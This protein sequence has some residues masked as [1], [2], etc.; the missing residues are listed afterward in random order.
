MCAN[1]SARARWGY[2]SISTRAT[3]AWVRAQP[4]SEERVPQVFISYSHKD[5]NKADQLV[6]RLHRQE[7]WR[8]QEITT[9][10]DD[11]QLQAG[12]FW[13][14]ELQKALDSSFA[15]VAICTRASMASSEVLFEIAYAIGRHIPVIPLIWDA[16]CNLQPFLEAY[17]RLD[18]SVSQD[19]AS[20]VLKLMKLSA[21]GSGAAKPCADSRVVSGDQ[22]ATELRQFAGEP[23][24][25]LDIFAYSGETFTA[26]LN[27]LFEAMMRADRPAQIFT[28]RVLL[29]DWESGSS[30]LPGCARTASVA[31]HNEKELYRNEIMRSQERIRDQLWKQ[32]DNWSRKLN[33][34]F[35]L[36]VYHIDPFHKG[37][38]INGRLGFWSLYPMERDISTK[39]PHILDYQGKYVSFAEFRSEGTPSEA[40]ALRS[41]CEWFNTVWESCC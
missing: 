30:F 17:Q 40:L 38:L 10:L 19:W 13:R 21:E 1:G 18:F 33:L 8:G 9:Y 4:E 11:Q 3:E 22:L 23:K 35:K 36:K 2:D 6:G 25:Q 7:I 41:L 34:T 24:L 16:G 26:P 15:V 27:G 12:S 37:I 5:R 29:K 20:L 31:I 14:P 32:L 39:H 28:L